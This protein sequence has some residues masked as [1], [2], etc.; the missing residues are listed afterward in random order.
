MTIVGFIVIG[1]ID[2]SRLNA[3]NPARLF[4]PIDYNGDI[5]GYNSA[6]KNLGKG[7]YLPDRSGIKLSD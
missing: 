7:Y 3:G 4:N 6:V 5:C 1:I 2:D